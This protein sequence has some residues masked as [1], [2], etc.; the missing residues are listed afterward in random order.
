V[1]AGVTGAR[2]LNSRWARVSDSSARGSKHNYFIPGLTSL[3]VCCKP[4]PPNST[5]ALDFSTTFPSD[6]LR[7][8][9][10]LFSPSNPACKKTKLILLG[11]FLFFFP[12]HTRAMIEELSLSKGVPYLRNFFFLCDVTSAL[13]FPFFGCFGNL[14]TPLRQ[15]TFSP[16]QFHTFQRVFT[17]FLPES[18]PHVKTQRFFKSSV[19]PRCG[20]LVLIAKQSSFGASIPPLR[21]FFQPRLI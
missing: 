4:L 18:S 2:P 16:D 15:Y 1:P 21:N 6:H 7:P 13:P 20:G 17:P 19:H 11:Q 12:P 8:H 3:S 10:L 5:T 14:I 9:Q